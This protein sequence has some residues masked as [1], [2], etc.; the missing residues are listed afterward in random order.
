MTDNK[1]TEYCLSPADTPK[2]T[3]GTPASDLRV[4]PLQPQHTPAKDYGS[5]EDAPTRQNLTNTQIPPSV[6]LDM[7]LEAE[8]EHNRNHKRRKGKLFLTLL[9]ILFAVY[10]VGVSL[11]VFAG[12]ESLSLGECLILIS[13]TAAACIPA[14]AITAAFYYW[15]ITFAYTRAFAGDFDELYQIEHIKDRIRGR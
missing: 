2:D 5:G 8:I 10:A 4:E 11:I 14:A 13:A 7:L 3:K 12:Y 1:P 15:L 9:V 6:L